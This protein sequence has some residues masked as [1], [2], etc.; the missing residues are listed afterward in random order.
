M[1][2]KETAHEIVNIVLKRYDIMED[3]NQEEFDE[4]IVEIQ[5][6]IFTVRI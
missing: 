3:L 2:S 1:I 5:E 4:M 6:C